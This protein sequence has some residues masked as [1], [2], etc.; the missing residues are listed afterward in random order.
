MEAQYNQLE[1]GR[2]DMR[3]RMDYL[4]SLLNMHRKYEP[5]QKIN[6]EYWKLKKA[7]ETKGKGGFLG[8]AKKSE[9]E[10]Y[11]MEYQ[12][13]LTTYKMYRNVIK[14]MIVEQDFKSVLKLWQKELDGLKEKYAKTQRLFSG[15]VVDL[16]KVEVFNHNRKDLER[17]LEKENHKRAISKERNI[18]I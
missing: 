5:Y 18:T 16:A 6:V 11:R 15:A 10:K 14:G 7:K 3:G 4:E 17:M 8:F 1:K 9:A 2:T 13:E 12:I